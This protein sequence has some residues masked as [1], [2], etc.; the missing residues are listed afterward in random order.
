M[1]KGLHILLVDD[2]RL[3][4]MLVRRLLPAAGSIRE[5]ATAKE[6][7][8]CLAE[9]VPDL[10]LLDNRLP[11]VDGVD[12]VPL[13]AER[14][15]PVVMLTEIEAPE[16]IVHAMQRGAQDYLVKST[17]SPEVLSR[18][19]NNAV[20]KA[21]MQRTLAEQQEA[22]ARQAAALRE[23]NREIRALAS[24]L[25]LAE[26]EERRRISE[27]LHDHVQQ[28][29]LGA[30]LHLRM[31]TTVP[32]DE[33]EEV[34]ER[35]ASILQDA[36]QATREL[37]VELTPPVLEEEAL[38]EAMRWVAQHMAQLY[39]FTV[40]V[41]AEAHGLAVPRDVRVLLLQFV[42]ELLINS[43]KHAQV[44]EARVHI[45]EDDQRLRVV[46]EDEG[47]GFDVERMGQRP[48]GFGLASIRERLELLGGELDVISGPGSGTRV[49]IVLPVGEG[50]H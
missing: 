33:R 49:T 24:A 12:L 7:R 14:H 43:I 3:D 20:E 34:A 10:A 50:A 13:F 17:L 2:N 18:A 45:A 36:L 5:A 15:V 9:A 39:R 31:L 19:I 44:S 32:P 37:A 22:L 28:L 29:I 30:K 1:I 42:R 35:V 38:G 16:V 8:A 25:A 48:S 21:A 27:L 47:A 6:A 23:R 40:H 4:R 26:Q 11:D 41:Q 46:V